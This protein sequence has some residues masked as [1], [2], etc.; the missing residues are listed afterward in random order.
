MTFLLGLS[1]KKKPDTLRKNIV[2]TQSCIFDSI[3]FSTNIRMQKLGRLQ[4]ET[5]IKSSTRDLKNKESHFEALTKLKNNKNQVEPKLNSLSVCIFPALRTRN[6]HTRKTI[7]LNQNVVNLGPAFSSC[8][9]ARTFY[10]PEL[11][12]MQLLRLLATKAVEGEAPLHIN[13]PFC[14]L[15]SQLL[16]NFLLLWSRPMSTETIAN[17][18]GTPPPFRVIHPL[19]PPGNSLWF[20]LL[21]P[22]P[23]LPRRTR[24]AFSLF[25]LFF[26]VYSIL[27]WSTL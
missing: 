3:W 10:S 5:K 4:I 19:A 11:L 16:T 8:D 18:W 15:S 1:L 20:L 14:I 23:S 6:T 12:D 26:N 9:E 27:T 2:F 24:G 25:N 13:Q 17:V 7:G 22:I 21:K